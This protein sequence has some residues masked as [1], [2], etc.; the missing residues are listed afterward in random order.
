MEPED[1]YTPWE[2][3][4]LDRER[5]DC[6][7]AGIPFPFRFSCLS[8]GASLSSQSPS[9]WEGGQVDLEPEDVYTPWELAELD[10]ERVDCERAGIL[11]PLR[12]SCL[13]VG[14]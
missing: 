6:E 12:F 4:E 7:R 2:L 13:S 11:F 14:A 5:V 3:A 9:I 8:V 1:V 10:R